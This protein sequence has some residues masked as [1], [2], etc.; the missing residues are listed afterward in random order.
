MTPLALAFDF[1]FWY[2]FCWIIGV[3][4]IGIVCGLIEA[5]EEAFEQSKVYTRIPKVAATLWKGKEA[6]DKERNE[7]SRTRT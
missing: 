5:F 2:P 1:L 6:T 4:F 7:M 3:P